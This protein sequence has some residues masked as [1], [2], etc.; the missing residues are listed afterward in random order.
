MGEDLLKKLKGFSR[1]FVVHSNTN[2]YAAVAVAGMMAARSQDAGRYFCVSDTFVPMLDALAP[3][4]HN[5]SPDPNQINLNFKN[6]WIGYL[7]ESALPACGLK[8]T[9][10][11]SPEDNTTRFLNAYNRRIPSAK[12]RTVHVSKD[13]AVPPQFQQDYEA[14]VALLKAGGDLKPYLSRQVAKRKRPDWPDPLLNSWGIQHLHFRRE[15]TDHLLFCVLAD[16][17]VYLIQVFPHGRRAMGQHRAHSNLARQLAGDNCTRE[18]QPHEA[19]GIRYVE[20]PITSQLQR[21]FRGDCRGRDGLS[22]PC[23]RNN[24]IR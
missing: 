5:S 21:E 14:L 20:A 17:D 2:P 4:D 16:A 11:L 9:E 24:R 13:L 7:R 19:R 12:P 15:G 6:D 1:T 22:S 18:S 3:E 10:K 23:G 8:Y